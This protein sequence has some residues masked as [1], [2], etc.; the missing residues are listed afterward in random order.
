MSQGKH[1]SSS[2]GNTTNVNKQGRFSV[3]KPYILMAV[4]VGLLFVLQAALNVSLRLFLK[5]EATLKNV[6]NERDE[7]MQKLKNYGYEL[8]GWSYF[9]GSFYYIS[10]NSA[11]W[12]HSRNYCLSKGADLVIVNNALENDLLK[13]FKQISWIGLYKEGSSWRWVDGSYLSISFWMDG[14]PNYEEDCEDRVE[15]RQCGEFLKWNDAP[16]TK[17]NY[18][19]CEKKV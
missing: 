4:S 10:T 17:K 7:L 9:Q 15:I 6:T 3:R 19:I 16:Q 12:Q 2:H 1:G 8:D 5:T 11:D 14:E 13:G 18:W